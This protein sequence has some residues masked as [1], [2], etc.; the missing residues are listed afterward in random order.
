M[1]EG[2]RCVSLDVQTPVW[3]LVLAAKALRSDLVALSFTGCMGPNQ[4]ASGLAELHAKLPPG[5]AVWAGG[6]APVLSRRPVAGVQA[7]AS[8]ADVPAAIRNLRARA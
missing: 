5:V 7:F 4:I 8:L 6:S 3:D 1:L 2:C